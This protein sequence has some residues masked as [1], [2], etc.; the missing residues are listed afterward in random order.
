MPA[1]QILKLAAGSA[2][3][4]TSCPLKKRAQRAAADNEAEAALRLS[5]RSASLPG[6]YLFG[7]LLV[8]S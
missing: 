3:S 6:G 7:S 5:W 2:G 8:L 4:R 1:E